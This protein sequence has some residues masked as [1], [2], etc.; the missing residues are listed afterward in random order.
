MLDGIKTEDQEVIVIQSIMQVLAE[1][2]GKQEQVH[3][4]DIVTLLKDGQA[5]Q[6]EEKTTI[7][8]HLI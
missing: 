2:K 7:T 8:C 3:L 1:P 4:E 5:E 6:V